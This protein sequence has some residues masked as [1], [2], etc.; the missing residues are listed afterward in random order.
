LAHSMDGCCGS[1]KRMEV[2][3]TRMKEHAEVWQKRSR[4][5]RG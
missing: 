5:G 4:F 3:T 1:G 2:E